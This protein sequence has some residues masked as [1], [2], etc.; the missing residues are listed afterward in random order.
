MGDAATYKSGGL[1]AHIDY[2]IAKTSGSLLVGTANRGVCAVT[3]G[4]SVSALKPRLNRN[5]RPH[6]GPD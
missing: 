2:V 6:R 5:I 1:G 4:D 3:L